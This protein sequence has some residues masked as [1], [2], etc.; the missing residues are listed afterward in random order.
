[1][2]DHAIALMASGYEWTCPFCDTFNEETSRSDKIQC[3]KCEMEFKVRH[4]D[5]HHV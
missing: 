5:Y 1:M 3:G 4:D 2:A